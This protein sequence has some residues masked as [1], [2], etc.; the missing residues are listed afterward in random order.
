MYA[1]LNTPEAMATLIEKC[2]LTP[3]LGVPCLSGSAQI[4]G[5][6]ATYPDVIQVYADSNPRV[7]DPYRLFMIGSKTFAYKEII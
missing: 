5:D 6:D 4:F 3:F 2:G 7:T 1:F